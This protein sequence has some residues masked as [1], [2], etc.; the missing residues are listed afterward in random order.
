M[1]GLRYFE[2]VMSDLLEA[3]RAKE[4]L[5]QRATSYAQ[6]CE[7]IRVASL[8]RTDRPSPSFHRATEGL[9]AVRIITGEGR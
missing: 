8:P 5:H 6:S 1:S 9:C 7:Q 4:A 3:D 2:D